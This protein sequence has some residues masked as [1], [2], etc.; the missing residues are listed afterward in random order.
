MMRTICCHTSSLMNDKDSGSWT[1][2]VEMTLESTDGVEITINF[3]DLRVVDN[4]GMT[5]VEASL[6][7]HE[8]ARKMY[9]GQVV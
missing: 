4:H 3:Q 6:M 7:L 9:L 1:G 2:D 5:E 8:L